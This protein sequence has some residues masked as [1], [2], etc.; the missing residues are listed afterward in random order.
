[1]APRS[2]QDG[3]RVAEPD[4]T[5]IE[6]LAALRRYDILDTPPEPEFDD[7][8]ALLKTICEVPI[9]LVSLVDDCRQWFKAKVGT[10]AQQT[11]IDTSVCALAIQQSGTFVIEDLSAD[12]RTAHM[13][14]VTDD[15]KIRFY[16]G[17]PLITSEGFPLGSLCAID[18][19]PRPGGLTPAQDVALRALGRQVVAQIELRSAITSRDRAIAEQE[20][21]Q[22]QATR[23]SAILHTMLQAQQRVL[24]AGGDFDTVLQALVDAA[25]AAVR[26]AQGV[27]VEMRD[28]DD[29]VYRA[30]AGSASGRLGLRIPI[31]GS[32]AGR[33]LIEETALVSADAPHDGRGNRE[34]I[35]E[36]GIA[37]LV[38]VPMSRHGET[39]GVLKFHSAKAN[40]FKSRH[41]LIGQML[42]GLIAASFSES[43]EAD[44][45]RAAEK[46]EE[47][48]R[49]IVDSAIDSAIIST[50]AEGLITSW[51]RGAETI[52][53]WSE[54]EMLGQPLAR[55]F[56]PE[57]NALGRPQREMALAK[58]EGRASD[59]RWHIRKD[60]SRY[61]AHG[62]VT[63]LL[64]GPGKGFV[65][66]LRDVTAEHETRTAL[67]S[68]RL[69]LETALET[70]LIGF[71]HWDVPSRVVSGD[72]RFAEFFD[73]DRDAAQSGV[74]VDSAFH[75]I[76]PADRDEVNAL[77]LEQSEVCADYSQSY[78]TYRKDG[79]IRWLRVRGRCVEKDGTRPLVYVGTAV[80][81]TQQREAEER[82][83]FSGERLELA[84]R[85][86]RLGSF[87][88]LPQSDQL[89]WDDRCRELFGLSPGAP[90]SYETAFLAGLHPDDRDATDAAVLASLDPAGSGMFDVEYRTIGIEDGIERSILA[91]GLATFIDD[92]PV[93]LIG[94]VQ[95]VTADREARAQ[96]RDAEERFRL[97]IRATNDAI[98]D[99]DLHRDHIRW[100]EALHAGYGHTPETVE[101]TEGWWLD[102]IHPDDRDRVS[103]GIHA[104][105]RGSDNDWADEYRF[106]RAD[107]SHAD[108]HDRGYLIRNEQGQA[109]RM[110][111]ALH[112]QSERKQ[113]ERALTAINEDLEAAVAERTEELNRLW[114]T[115]PDLLLMLAF[116]GTIRRANPAW[117]THLGYEPRDL[118]GRDIMSLVYPDDVAI[119]IRA[120]GDAAEG[121][122]PTVE[123][124]YVHKDGSLRWFAWVAAP[125]GRE[126]YATGRHITAEKE[127]EA[128]LRSTEEQLRQSQ[129][130]EAIGQ[131][132]GGVAHDFNNLLTVIRGSTDLLRLPNLSED[133]R[134]RY[135]DAISDT[136]DRATKLTAQLLAFARRSSL[137]PEIFEVGAAIRSLQEMMGTLAGSLIEVD[138]QIPAEPCY[139]DADLSQFDTAIVN[140]AVNARDAMD[141]KGRLTIDVRPVGIVPAARTHGRLT[142]DFIAVSITDT[143]MGIP[144]HIIDR[145][146]EPFYTS[147]D[148]GE[149]TGLGLSQV[150]GFAKQSGGEILVD[151]APGQGATF[152][153]YLPRA[154]A[155]GK[156]EK[157][158]A[159]IAAPYRK[160][161]RILVVED[162]ADVNAFATAAL[163]EI[164][165]FTVHV[166]NGE[167][168]LATLGTSA[169]SFDVVFSDVVMPGMSGIELAQEIERLYPRLPVLLA[170]GY[171]SVLAV[172]GSHGFPLLHKPYSIESLSRALAT[173]INDAQA[174]EATMTR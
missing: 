144:S 141:R 130:V 123:N 74:P 15:P 163:A 86:A 24:H 95:D 142:G 100:N 14:L 67:E 164:G 45:W 92:R 160:G 132:T 168:A 28:G 83:R 80:D 55:I 89:D 2:K 22:D 150:F 19:V 82:L 47:S 63:P 173:L 161:L 134:K 90:V 85:A 127:A 84:T 137:Q 50:D 34:A 115:S 157:P 65:K 33:A 11:D 174:A 121:P 124:R 35:E 154:A 97:A 109:I 118:L 25:L 166:V 120:L 117:R 51:S 128:Q 6:R 88:Y 153:L 107:G 39:F 43:A 58:R 102:H 17:T 71:F 129:K 16:A 131:L 101:P 52:M 57:D 29:L 87:D 146:F 73:L 98:W 136:A 61:Y 147:K 12:P 78:R 96:L 77:F 167:E 23:D 3:L 46:S 94:T 170:S 59:E 133:K 119:T 105:I 60:G 112:D 1:M 75:N 20:R 76:L 18:I 110:I 99:W 165:H 27:V 48:Y 125:T 79:R 8:V 10:D 41:V 68:S 159:A 70:G 145:I 114:E 126:I 148:V 138:V 152:T 156:S 54:S 169:A 5:E 135:I 171:S 56:T 62:A 13:S 37:S 36:L 104:L 162:N 93:R 158:P 40:A 32:F 122:L 4:W 155:A 42:A 30:A 72:S 53:G 38:V 26:P 108:V 106:R 69:R 64:G 139:I 140:M 91:R 66:S 113:I 149:G 172:E 31:A 44:A 111:G 81:V 151:S 103:D 21:R 7:S 49:H 116:D 143:G 9:A